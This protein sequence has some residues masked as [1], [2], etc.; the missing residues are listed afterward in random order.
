KKRYI[1]KDGK[2]FIKS[3]DLTE[4]SVNDNGDYFLNDK[5][6]G[7]YNVNGLFKQE[8]TFYLKSIYSD[9][10]GATWSKPYSLNHV[11]KQPYMSFIGAGPGCGIVLQN[12]KH[13]GRVL[14]PIYFGTRKFS[15]SLSCVMLYSD[16]NGI[17]WKMGVSPNDT[18]K[19][20][21]GITRRVRLITNNKMLTESQAIELDDGT[22]R[23]YMRNH[24]LRRRVAVAE[25]YDGGVTF[26]NFRFMEQ[27]PQPICQQSVIRFKKDCKPYVVF[28]NAASEKKRENGVVRLS[29]DDGLT[30]PYS[31]QLKDGEFVYSSTAL[32]PDG[33][34]GVLFE[35][36]TTH[37]KIDFAKFPIEWITE[38]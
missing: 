3:C 15:L 21:F 10:D 14:M 35:G 9:D 6:I 19:N 1:A 13:K 5:K 18:R 20:M 12:G 33:K 7:N 28:V 8:E 2:I 24:E 31:R 29:L 32:L 23:L 27:L 22:V 30:F 25:S 4:Y 37:T 26:E 11:V 16:D 34:I 17:N 36:E 38:K